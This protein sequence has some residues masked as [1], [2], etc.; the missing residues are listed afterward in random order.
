[1]SPLVAQYV[2]KE[3]ILLRSLI[4]EVLLVTSPTRAQ[5]S[6]NPACQSRKSMTYYG[7]HNGEAVVARTPSQSVIGARST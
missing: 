1:M 7:D 6:L 2:P 4:P 3:A 5:F